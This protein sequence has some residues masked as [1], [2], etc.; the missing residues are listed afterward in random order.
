[1]GLINLKT[2]LKS[3]KYGYDRP[4]GGSSNQPYIV[5]PI[6]D[7]LTFNGPDF[8]LR[9]GALQDS[10]TDIERLTKFFT[11]TSSVRGLLF[12]AKQELLE[13]QNPK[14]INTNRIYLPT[15]TITQAG[16]LALGTHFNKQGLDP[17]SP[18]SYFAGG[19]DGY[20][21]ATRGIGEYPTFQ[22]LA[23]GDIEN[24]LTIAYTAKVVNQPLGSLSINPFGI[25]SLLP[26]SLLAYTGGPNAELGLGITNIRIQ[27]PTI[28]LKDVYEDGEDRAAAIYNNP[29]IVS[30]LR[31]QNFLSHKTP[32]W[33]Y[34]PT[35]QGASFE[36]Q[37]YAGENGVD[38][39]YLFDQLYTGNISNI[40]NRDTTTIYNKPLG[41]TEVFINYVSTDPS[42][43]GYLTPKGEKGNIAPTNNYN[44]DQIMSV[45]ASQAYF[46]IYKDQLGEGGGF[47]LLSTEP[48]EIVERNSATKPIEYPE[49]REDVSSPADVSWVYDPSS[50]SNASTQ[51]ISTAAANPD[52][53]INQDLLL[54]E[55]YPNGLLTDKKNIPAIQVFSSSSFTSNP[56]TSLSALNPQYNILT[57]GNATPSPYANIKTF[58][59]ED[60][61]NKGYGTSHSSY[62]IAK[63]GNSVSK[64]RQD[65][66]SLHWDEI[67]E[68][69]VLENSDSKIPALK[70]KDLIRFF[71]EINNNNGSKDQN[72]FLFFRAYINNL[73]DNFNAEWQNFKYVGRGENFYRYSGFTRE[74]QLS[75]I[76]Y[77]HS[78]REMIPLYEKINYLAGTTAPDY[79]E[80]GYMRGNFTYITVGDYLNNVPSI[81]KSV[82]LKPSFE[83]GWD[84]N[85]KVNGSI[86][87]DSN[88]NIDN[89]LVGQVPRMIEVDLSFIPLHNFTPQFKKN[90][91]RDITTT[92]PSSQNQQTEDTT[93]ASV[94]NRNSAFGGGGGSGNLGFLNR[95]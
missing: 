73:S 31:G 48:K 57:N 68:E 40:L 9:K 64:T 34:N 85:R 32:T 8:L 18:L 80:A 52:N 28:K 77:A 59:R 22:T 29:N 60:N 15:N 79:S 76:I 45:G 17:L 89:L 30:A 63:L 1:M 69:P 12:V 88:K 90:F 41:N 78:R 66:T 91:I 75:F 24:R 23:N 6:P 74:M 81:I 86:I 44:I 71:F 33:I 51:Y 93:N 16:A 10:L 50:T 67:N 62:K 54:E 36:Y 5:T 65:N 46:D 37:V 72:F 82:S 25:T 7:G 83:A 87:S 49:Y 94:N 55:I 3:L 92:Q 2:D 56:D 27:N 26:N 19:T 20:Y 84:I 35:Q 39:G 14:M 11:D 95:G 43:P 42:K 4:G 13:R 21:F 47:R 58:N 61:S 53:K 38:D 70:N